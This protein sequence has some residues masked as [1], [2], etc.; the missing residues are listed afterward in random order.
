L[1]IV[2]APGR[3]L[4]E[5]MVRRHDGQIY[6][7]RSNQIVQFAMNCR[8]PL[9]R[10]TRVRQAIACAVDREQM[11]REIEGPDGLPAYSPVGPLSWAYEPNVARHP[12]DP[13]RA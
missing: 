6:S 13:A 12:Y 7:T 8:H 4:D 1:D 9:F 11:V 5:S 2:V 10:S 3:R